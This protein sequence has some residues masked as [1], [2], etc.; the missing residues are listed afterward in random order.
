MNTLDKILREVLAG[1]ESLL[2]RRD[3]LIAALEK[4]VPADLRRDF[5]SI[6]RALALN[7]GEK[8]FVGKTDKDATK[9]DVAQILKDGGLQASRIDFVID[10]FVKALDWDKP[11]IPVLPDDAAKNDDDSRNAPSVAEDIFRKART[12]AAKNESAQESTAP[13]V[14][15]DIFRNARADAAKNDDATERKAP[16][17]EETAQRNNFRRTQSQGAHAVLPQ[18]H[19]SK[20]FTT[21]GR[22]NR[23]A[24]FLQSLKV[25][26]LA[27]VG[28]L[29]AKL[30]VGVP[31]LIAAMVGGWMIGIRRLHDLNKSGWWLLVGFVPYVNI[32]FGLYVLFAPGTTGYNRY[33]ADPLT[34]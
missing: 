29:L 21:E 34:E 26:G 5:A 32:V 8:F 27:I 33:G 30:F 20:I 18:N 22:L 2:C 28:G 25:F 12:D 19:K 23:L 14:T 24:Y 1:D 10:T 13:H 9:T 3:E 4:K 15:E 31:I 17:A 11:M 7:V 6:K 16:R